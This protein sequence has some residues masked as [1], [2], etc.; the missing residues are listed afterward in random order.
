MQLGQSLCCTELKLN[1]EVQKIDKINHFETYC[2]GSLF[3]R[4]SRAC[5]FL[6]YKFLAFILELG[7]FAISWG[8]TFLS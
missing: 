7:S 4:S 1:E 8:G 6:F 2:S 3:A 5:F